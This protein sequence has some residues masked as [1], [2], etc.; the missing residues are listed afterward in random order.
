MDVM[1]SPDVS[2]VEPQLVPSRISVVLFEEAKVG[3]TH[4]VEC[5][6]VDQDLRLLAGVAKPA[7]VTVCEDSHISPSAEEMLSSPDLAGNAISGCTCWNTAPSGSCWPVCD[8]IPSDLTSLG[9]VGSN[10][11]PVGPCGMTSPSDLT[12][13]GPVCPITDPGGP[14]GPYVAHGPVGSH[15]MLS[16]C[17]S[18]PVGPYV[19]RGPM[20]LYGMLSPCD[21]DQLVADGRWARMLH[22]ARW[23]RMGCYPRVTLPLI[24]L[25]LLL[26]AR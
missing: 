17:D 20:G 10:P 2:V 1:N 3:G 25:S 8:D 15:G 24:L 22:V 16:L 23:A 26:M 21:S 5:P 13:I 9:L 14:V 11:G 12:S 7:S 4:R 19:A 18:D 6:R